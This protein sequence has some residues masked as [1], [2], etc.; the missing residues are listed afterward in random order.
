MLITWLFTTTEWTCA[1]IYYSTIG[2]W[3]DYSQLLEQVST[4]LSSYHSVFMEGNILRTRRRISPLVF[5]RWDIWSCAVMLDRQGVDRNNPCFE[6]HCLWRHEWWTVLLM[7]PCESSFLETL[8]QAPP[9]PVCLPSVYPMSPQVTKS[10]RPSP[11]V[12]A[13]HYDQRLEV[14]TAWEQ[15]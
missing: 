14:G 1:P 5:D 8:C 13:Y 15:G 10:P 6:L 7:L 9:P 12:F 2:Y 3:S 4:L 11:S